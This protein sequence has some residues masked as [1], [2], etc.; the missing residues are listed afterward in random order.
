[1]H[2]RDIL[3]LQAFVSGKLAMYL[4]QIPVVKKAW[5]NP[6]N[7]GKKVTRKVFTEEED[8]CWQRLRKGHQRKKT[9]VVE[10]ALPKVKTRKVK[11]A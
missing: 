7:K 10:V 4:A 1:M 5:R 9:R 8:S 3:I 2:K 6:E 11:L